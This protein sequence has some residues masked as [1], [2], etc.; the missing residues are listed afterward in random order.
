MLVKKHGGS[1]TLNYF[2]NLAVKTQGG[3][4]QVRSGHCAG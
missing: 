4:F 2:L 1:K 3:V